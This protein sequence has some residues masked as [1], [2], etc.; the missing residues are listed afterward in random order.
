VPVFVWFRQR[1]VG[2]LALLLLVLG[3]FAAGCTSALSQLS[4]EGTQIA[5]SQFYTGVL[6]PGG[7][8][9][10]QFTLGSTQSVG[11]ALVSLIS[12]STNLPDPSTLTLS[13][14]TPSGSTCKATN[15][16][17]NAVADLGA[18]FTP[19]LNAG[20]YC[21]SLAD[22][23]VLTS[24]DTY[25]IRVTETVGAPITNSTLTPTTYTSTLGRLGTTLHTFA[26]LYGGIMTIDLQVVGAGTP[27]VG[28]GLG[29][30]NAQTSTC[31][32]TVFLD[33]MPDNAGTSPQ[34]TVSADAG[35]YCL[36]VMD[37][38]N[39]TNQVPISVVIS[40]P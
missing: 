18:A 6:M 25:A 21:V 37:L 22:T 2:Q 26:T 31:Y 13:L 8:V 30:W 29:A 12:S 5:N 39:L 40:H 24:A 9:V 16:A 14:G 11:V 1:R 17:S 23:G 28:L 19:S 33:T 35:F 36:E 4:P 32:L 3:P 20:T 7:N 34:I 38:G 10:Y 27:T 15:T